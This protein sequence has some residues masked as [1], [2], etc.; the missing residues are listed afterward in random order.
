MGIIYN[1]DETR[2]KQI[3]SNIR[4][5]IESFNQAEDRAGSWEQQWDM[6]LPRRRRTGHIPHCM[7]WQT[8]ECMKINGQ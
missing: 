2:V 7:S 4:E 8:K 5:Q 1:T 6:R 3:I